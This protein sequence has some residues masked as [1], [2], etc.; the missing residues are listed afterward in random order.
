[1]ATIHPKPHLLSL[2]D[3]GDG[4]L[5]LT[6]KTHSGEINVQPVT[7]EMAARWLAR[8]AAFAVERLKQKGEK[9]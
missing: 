9:E 3:D 2:L 1:M 8:L 5:N 4:G 6:I 7:P